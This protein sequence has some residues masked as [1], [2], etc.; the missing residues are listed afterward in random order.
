MAKSSKLRVMLSSQCETPFPLNQKDKTLSDIRKSLKTEIESLKIAGKRA[1]DVWINE[2]TEPQ[3]GTSDSWEVCMQAVQDCDI[4]I[5]LS[6]GHAGWGKTGEDIGIC[7]AE[8]MTGL[9]VA[10][11]KV[12][13]IALG[14]VQITNDDEGKRN[15]LFQGYVEK[16]SLFR[17]GTVTNIEDLENRIKDALHD[18]VI[19]MAQSGVSQAS[20]GK[21]HHGTALDWS[22]MDFQR[23]QQEMVAVLRTALL[24]RANSDEIDGNILVSLGKPKTL[25]RTHAIPAPLS[26]A[27]AKEKVGQP[28]LE[29][30]LHVETLRN[31]KC[32]GPLHI[33]ACHRTATESQ[34]TKLLGFPDATVVSGPFGVFVADN[35]QKIQFAFI[36]NCRDE[37]TTRHGVQR[38]FEWLEQTGESEL[39]TT[40]AKS[41]ASI[42]KAIAKEISI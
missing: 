5:V 33:I 36:V 23:R 16:Q 14:K 32:G 20:K 11:A 26:I 22:R 29:D 10:P 21:F 28:F 42:V 13:L 17:G 27:A 34:A 1:F 8:L 24:G 15:K 6:T 37:T 4:L 18:A 40:R 2:E 39:V 30:H 19:K 7:H 9:S 25:V 31:K 12:R 38:F 35:I 3:G 41:R